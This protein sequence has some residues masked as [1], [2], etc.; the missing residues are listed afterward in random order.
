MTSAS[1]S[2]RRGGLSPPRSKN[3]GYVPANLT[4]KVVSPGRINDVDD[5]VKR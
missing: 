2:R 5:V 1:W 3:P 4:V